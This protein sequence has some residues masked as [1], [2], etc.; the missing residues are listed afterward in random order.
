MSSTASN[1]PGARF[2]LPGR[3]S[4]ARRY[5]MLEDHTATCRWALETGCFELRS[6]QRRPA[7][8]RQAKAIYSLAHGLPDAPA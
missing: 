6:P 2:N 1:P 3:L 5:D 4:W 7:R 8:S